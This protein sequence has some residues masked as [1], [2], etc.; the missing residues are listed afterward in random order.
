MQLEIPVWDSHSL[1][2]A[3]VY[4]FLPVGLGL[5]LLLFVFVSVIISFW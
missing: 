3:E 1:A 2:L 4:T 5:P